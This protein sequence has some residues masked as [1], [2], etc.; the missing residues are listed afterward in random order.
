MVEPDLNRTSFVIF[1]VWQRMED[2]GNRKKYVK[3]LYNG[4]PLKAFDGENCIALDE[5]EKRWSDIMIDEK[6]YFGQE[7]LCS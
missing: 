6:T 5:L 7:C 2:D 1:E 4:E 3:V